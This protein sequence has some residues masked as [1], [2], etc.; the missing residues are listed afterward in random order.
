MGNDL[1][2]VL[3]A[4]TPVPHVIHEAL[5]RRSS[6]CGTEENRAL[7][8]SYTELRLVCRES[9]NPEIL[10]ESPKEGVTPSP[11]RPLV[12]DTTPHFLSFLDLEDAALFSFLHDE[13]RC[14]RCKGRIG[15]VV[16]PSVCIGQ[17][18]YEAEQRHIFTQ[19][20]SIFLSKLVAVM[21]FVA[22]S[23]HEDYSQVTEGESPLDGDLVDTRPNTPNK[24]HSWIPHEL[25]LL[26]IQQGLLDDV[27]G[28]WLLRDIVEHMGRVL[29]YHS[30][31]SFL[32]GS[33]IHS[34]ISSGEMHE[35]LMS[36]ETST[37]SCVLTRVRAYG[38][39]NETSS[40]DSDT[41]QFVFCRSLQHV[42]LSQN[43]MSR[44][45]LR[46]CLL[47]LF[48]SSEQDQVSSTRP[49]QLIDVR[50]N[51]ETEATQRYVAELSSYTG[52]QINIGTSGKRWRHRAPYFI[53]KNLPHG[54][55]GAAGMTHAFPEDTPYSGPN[56]AETTSSSLRKDQSLLPE[57]INRHS[58]GSMSD[59]SQMMPHF[60][61][62]GRSLF[63]S[64]SEEPRN[65]EV[66]KLNA[67]FNFTA[68]AAPAAATAATTTTTA[69]APGKKGG[70]MEPKPS[71]SMS[72]ESLL[73]DEDDVN[74][75]EV[76]EKRMH[77]RRLDGAGELEAEAAHHKELLEIQ[78]GLL[79][80]SPA[81]PP[82]SFSRI[83]QHE[84]DPVLQDV[85]SSKH[86]VG[87]SS[88]DC[89]ASVLLVESI[90][91]PESSDS[92]PYIVGRDQTS[93]ADHVVS[94]PPT[95][96]KKKTR[97]R[98]R[99]APPAAKSGKS[100][101]ATKRSHPNSHDTT[102]KEANSLDFCRQQRPDVSPTSR[103]NKCATGERG[104]APNKVPTIE[105]N[106]NGGLT[107][108]NK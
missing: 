62:E 25:F 18:L 11:V 94:V 46:K 36:G 37:S 60:E 97:S 32:C 105:K 30:A 57:K 85:I 59:S 8:I 108:V 23:C 92:L 31:V 86:E 34:V 107:C 95:Q 89:V 72:R 78:T 4:C 99:N 56:M 1:S 33:S 83:Q 13:L 42:L 81:T 19:S 74:E 100:V 103:T 52:V 39:M 106:N 66:K 21:K 48:N 58:V 68:A 40:P 69:A 67:A 63:A 73:L 16:D 49:L 82:V 90:D 45:G 6:S 5:K 102:L 61:R 91:K 14:K 28:P 47:E 9:F 88:A 2:V 101:R 80:D 98:P 84:T 38:D 17:R 65:E 79:S 3:R 75:G 15:L 35:K 51:D 104:N 93:V 64:Y 70:K 29:H 20:F 27:S 54:G 55:I 87:D 76:D 41:A 10:T 71:E 53:R 22:P 50:E 12:T 43:N 24:L 26:E 77:S 7:P 44:V 96:S